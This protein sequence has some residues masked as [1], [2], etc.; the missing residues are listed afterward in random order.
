[1]DEILHFLLSESLSAI[2]SRL[3]ALNSYISLDT[4]F[5]RV[6]RSMSRIIEFQ[7]RLGGFGIGMFQPRRQ[8][9]SK[10]YGGDQ[11]AILAHDF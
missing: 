6:V 4:A 7:Y 5:A 8:I 10:R 9:G 3:S 1:V 2:L 11:I